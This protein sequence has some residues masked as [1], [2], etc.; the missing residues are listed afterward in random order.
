MIWKIQWALDL[1]RQIAVNPC[2]NALALQAQA[3]K[4]FL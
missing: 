3:R 1:D 2:P 4:Q